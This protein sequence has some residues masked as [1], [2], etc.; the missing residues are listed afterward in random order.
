MILFL[1]LKVHGHA[2]PSPN[3]AHLQTSRAQTTVQIFGFE[4]GL[5]NTQGTDWFKSI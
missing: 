1:P 4:D 3:E 2:H 5:L